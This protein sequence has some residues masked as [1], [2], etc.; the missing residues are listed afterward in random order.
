MK[1]SKLVPF[2]K[3]AALVAGVLGVSVGLRAAEVFSPNE[4]P[5]GWLPPPALS[6]GWLKYDAVLNPTTGGG[7]FAYLSWFENTAWQGDMIEWTVGADG[8][9]STSVENTTPPTNT[10]AINWSAREQLISATASD[11]TI[12]EYT[13]WWNTGRKMITV[14]SE[15]QKAFRWANLTSAQKDVLDLTTNTTTP[16]AT[17]SPILNYVRG[18]TWLEAGAGHSGSYRNRYSLLGD[19]QHSNPVYVAKP[20]AKY[21]FGDYDLFKADY[22][23]RAGRV[24]VGANDGALHVFNAET[25]DEVYAYVPSMVYSKLSP[26]AAVPYVHTYSV[27]GPLTAA[28]AQTDDSGTKDDWRTLLVGGLG[29]GGKGVFILDITNADLSAENSTATADQKV[30]YELDDTHSGVG[31]DLGY[32]YSKAVVARLPDGDWYAVMGNGYNSANGQAKL[33]LINLRTKAPSVIATD[34][35]GSGTAPNGLS[36]PVLV[37]SNADYKADYAYAG[38]LDGNVWK[39]NLDSKTLSY[40]LFSAGSTKPITTAPD[41]ISYRSG[42]LVY[43]ATGRLL[44]L[45]DLETTD[46]QSVFAVLD[47]GATVTEGLLVTQTLTQ[48]TYTTSDP[49]RLVRYSSNTEIDWTTKKGWKIDFPLPGERVITHPQVRAERLQFVT[50]IPSVSASATNWLVEPNYLTGGSP[51]ST[52]L[53]LNDDH[54]LTSDDNIDANSDGDVTDIGDRVSA[55]NLEDGITSQPAFAIIDEVTGVG[56]IDTVFI[57]NVELPAVDVCTMDCIGGFLSGGIDVMTDSPYGPVVGAINDAVTVSADGL[58]GSPDGHQHSYDKVHGQVYVDLMGASSLD[59]DPV[60][61]DRAGKLEPRRNLT[62]LNAASYDEDVSQALNSVEEV[63]KSSGGSPPIDSAKKFFVV[64]TN[65]DLSTS[66]QI[67]IGNTTWN[68]K[69]YQDLMATKLASYLDGASHSLT[70]LTDG[71][72]NLLFTMADLTGSGKTLRVSFTSE[73]IRSGGVHGTQA[74]CVSGDKKWDGTSASPSANL[75]ITPVPT[76]SSRDPSADVGYRWRNGALTIQLLDAS[77]FT[78]EA[79]NNGLSGSNKKYLLPHSRRGSTYTLVGGVHAKAF[80][81]DGSGTMTL[82]EG[83]NESGLLYEAVIFWHYGDLAYMRDGHV[84]NCFGG[85]NWQSDLNVELAGINLGE[86]N[87][88]LD[89][90]TDTST[91]ITAYVAALSAVASCLESSS[92]SEETLTARVKTLSEAIVPIAEYERMRG[93]V[94]HSL[95]PDQHLLSI[96]SEDSSSS[97]SSDDPPDEVTTRVIDVGETQGPNFVRGRRTWTEIT[98]KR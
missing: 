55:V 7:G 5:P 27:D 61:T 11:S 75:H 86:Y 56:T 64:V 77:G 91:E 18:D 31:A 98:P 93:Y 68:A 59:N 6:T 76:G 23:T 9:R 8:T 97:S 40:K 35:S 94:P 85:S 43:F 33:L 60:T 69:T 53:D 19:I 57:N 46:Q 88:V 79:T 16:S 21:N 58:G 44:N 78:L 87:A 41:L 3:I 10:T 12:D 15:T 65:A 95:V 37:D 62:S 39:F 28:D 4:Q 74:Y 90:L 45:A 82:T 54:S 52:V 2:V 73:D 71:S 83:S 47:T 14:V 51:N 48:K 38:D 22:L 89:G 32:T 96:D 80:T 29:A 72:T 20:I 66:A 42:Y 17:T 50:T 24:Y 26:L 36:T 70:S 25:G 1:Q 84:A 49:D 92:C 34:G 13:Q 63:N 67:T 81:V 30:F